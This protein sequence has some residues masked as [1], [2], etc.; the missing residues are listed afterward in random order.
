V[1]RSF[2]L[3]APDGRRAVGDLILVPHSAQELLDMTPARSRQ[4]VEDAIALAA[5]RDAQVV[6]LGGFTAV[7]TEGGR[8]L[9]APAPVALT[10]GNALTALTAVQAVEAALGLV[11]DEVA[12]T[13]AMVFGAFGSIGGAIAKLLARRVSRLV[14]VVRRENEAIV[15]RRADELR[16]GL[17][18]SLASD[19]PP[20]TS[21]AAALAGGH[22]VGETFV[23][24]CDPGP[25]WQACRVVVTATSALSE[26]VS[27]A[28]L[29]PGTVVC[30]VSRPMNVARNLE[31]E[32]P[33]VVLIE[34]GVLV[35]PPPF[36]CGID[37]GIGRDRSYACMAETMLLALE[38]DTTHATLGSEVDLG[39]L[40]WLAE[41]AR[42]AGFS[43]PER[44]RR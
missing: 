21:A 29:A 31:D 2:A 5:R 44:Q 13:T 20:P 43:L 27:A 35:P 32:R 22:D 3:T 6:G 1:I 36:D 8:A 9:D 14:L 37:L 30:D 25:Y 4:L 40:P 39:A 38:R 7:V 11:A 33:D 12:P 10:T 34:G 28:N 19:H 18:K 17:L 16:H 24:T 26:L 23:V 42:R 41:A 15:R